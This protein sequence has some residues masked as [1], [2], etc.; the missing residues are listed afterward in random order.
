MIAKKEQRTPRW[1]VAL[2]FQGLG[3]HPEMR[4]EPDRTPRQTYAFRL[5]DSYSPGMFKHIKRKKLNCKPR[6]RKK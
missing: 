2:V 4:Q 3:F 1:Q 6:K 5:R